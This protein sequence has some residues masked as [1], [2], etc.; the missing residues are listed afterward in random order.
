MA[1]MASLSLSSSSLRSSL[2]SP[3]SF[4]RDLEL[5]RGEK[6]SFSRCDR[7]RCVTRM[8]VPE[9]V[10]ALQL[11]IVPEAHQSMVQLY[12]DILHSAVKLGVPLPVDENALAYW[13]VALPA[14]LL[15]STAAP[16]P[17][18]GLVD[19][20]QGHSNSPP[21]FRAYEVEIGRQMGEG[22]FG[23]VYE[24]LVYKGGKRPGK[25]PVRVVLKK[26]KAGV[27]GGDDMRNAEIHMNRRLQRTAPEAC[28]EFLGTVDVPSSLARGKLTEG[29]WLIW[30]Y[31][32]YKTLD[33]CM[34]QKNF[35]ENISEVVLGQKIKNRGSKAAPRNQE[36]LVVQ[37][38]MQ[39]VLTNLR[40]LHRSGVVHRDLKPLNLV[41]SEDSGSFKL[42]DLG[43]C[44][45]IRSGFNYT[46]DETV[47]D[48]TYA[49]PEH[50]V[51]PTCTP[52]LP[53]DP[54]CSII[55][56]VVWLL[57]TPDRFDLYS[58]GLILMQL[59][60]KQLRQDVGLQTF[61]THFKRAGYDLD[62]WRKRCTLSSEEFAILDA[63]GGAGWE[64][65]KAM[66]QPRHD[67]A[68]NIWPSAGLRSSRPSAAA[69]LR[70]RFI[71][72]TLLPLPLSIPKLVPDFTSFPSLP[73]LPSV[74]SLPS[75][76][77]LQVPA[78]FG[79]SAVESAVGRLRNIQEAA[80]NIDSERVQTALKSTVPTAAT[81]AFVLATGWIA[82][83]T[84]KNSA[85]VSYDMGRWMIQTLG[86][87]G[88]ACLA[89]FLFI[90]PWLDEQ[91]FA[92]RREREIRLEAEPLAR[93]GVV[94]SDYP[95]YDQVKLL[96][97]GR[98]PGTV[99]FKTGLS[100]AVLAM[101]A[102]LV[103]LE[104]SILRGQEFSAQQR[105]T[106][107]RVEKLLI[108]RTGAT[109]ASSSEGT[110]VPLSTNGAFAGKSFSEFIS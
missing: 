78:F 74:P 20:V 57:N 17:I 16:G 60:V 56:P 7:G 22:S 24:G 77:Q 48:P 80:Q 26:S 39:Q 12:H 59:S 71:R 72:G 106:L 85:H 104:A 40:D 13:D 15:Y 32:G 95:V 110:D 101:E 66:L 98:E 5:K 99:R 37:K 43:A 18:A 81:S 84:V 68:S 47:I 105:E 65:A 55:S 50:Y 11:G 94:C 25:Q 31:Q 1:A 100:E 44:V 23:I 97:A 10:E 75:L 109:Y 103:S 35:P 53:P 70:H 87:G 49:A 9:L 93:V 88:S 28:A 82:L 76:A 27:A 86:L 6:R 63:D 42:I 83:T 91:E 41:L 73:S 46:P 3:C 108:T 64:L 62:V 34:K 30:K 92:S 51:M 52:T 90:K 8:A 45:D 102:Q 36:V 21:V 19:F 79:K 107:T 29:V 14:A 67:K 33:Y 38:I 4:R 54:L 89:F 61:N 69:A 96:P 2:F 58:S